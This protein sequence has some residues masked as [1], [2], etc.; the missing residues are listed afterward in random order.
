MRIYLRDRSVPEL[1]DLRWRQR[2]K[3]TLPAAIYTLR[4]WQSWVALGL[5]C[6][7]GGSVVW[8]GEL[9]RWWFR[10]LPPMPVV[11]LWLAGSAV[12]VIAAVVVAVQIQV[13]MM[14]RYL[15]RQR[16]E[17]CNGCGYPI[18]TPLQAGH[19]SCPECGEPIAA[20]QIDEIG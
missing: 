10:G 5:C 7:A 6:L 4:C 2:V 14:R 20:W 17:L 19:E 9:A 12:L 8:L 15:Q 18:T 11:F 3:L 16:P 1:A 13:R